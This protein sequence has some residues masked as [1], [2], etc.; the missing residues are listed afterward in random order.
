MESCTALNIQDSLQRVPLDVGHH[1][2]T[3]PLSRTERFLSNHYRP[4][5]EFTDSEGG[6]LSSSPSACIHFKNLFSAKILW[7]ASPHNRSQR[8]KYLHNRSSLPHVKSP[9]SRKTPSTACLGSN[10]RF[11]RCISSHSHSSLS[12]QISGILPQQK[13]IL[14]PSSSVRSERSPLHLYTTDEMAPISA[15][16][17]IYRCHSL[18]GRLDNLESECSSNPE[19]SARNHTST[20]VLRSFNKLEE[21][22]SNTVSR[23]NLAGSPMAHIQGKM[24]HTFNKNNEDQDFNFGNFVNT[25]GNSSTMGK[26][27]RV[28]KLHLPDTQTLTTTSSTLTQSSIISSSFSKRSTCSSP[29]STRRGFEEM[30]RREDLLPTC[31]LPAHKEYNPPLDGRL[32]IRVGRSHSLPTSLWRMEPSGSTTPYK[33]TGSKSSHKSYPGT[34]P[35]EC[36]N[37][38]LY[39]QSGSTVCYQQTEVQITEIATRD[40]VAISSNRT[41]AHPN[42]SIQDLVSDEQP[43][44]STQQKSLSILGVGDPPSNFS[45]H[46]ELEG[47]TPHRSNGNFT[48]CKITDLHIG[49]ERPKCNSHQCHSPRLES[50][51]R[52]IHFSPEVANPSSNR[53]TRPLQTPRSDNPPMVPSRALVQQNPAT[54]DIIQRTELTRS[55]E[56]WTSSLREM[57]RLQFLKQVLT[58]QHD[59][60]IAEELIQAHRS[61]T[62]KQAQSVWK[63]FKN[64]LP[65][66]ISKITKDTVLHFL[67]YLNEV[68]GL[69]PQT[70][71]NYKSCLAWPLKTAF[72]LNL[73]ESCFSLLT[74]TQFLKNPPRR[75]KIPTWSIDKALETFSSRAF[76]N[77]II[78]GEKLLLKALFLT[79]LATGNRAS[80]L[81]STIREGVVMNN[82]MVHLPVQRSFLFKNQSVSN[83]SPP[84]INFPVL[85]NNNTLCPW[86]C[87]KKY[88]ET[89][90]RESH[91]GFIFINPKSFKPLKAG[92]F[93]YWL[94]KSIRMADDAAIKPAGHDVRKFGHSIAFTRGEDPT[95]I[96]KNGFWH[97]PNVFVHKYLISC[98]SSSNKQFVAGRT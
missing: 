84:S 48:Q 53:K 21:I 30:A 13:V 88:I 98:N 8:T 20:T 94:V 4:R 18:S 29:I 10:S 22:K 32:P 77:Q 56:R 91:E 43:R 57:D 81:A 11:T 17:K 97:S 71:L 23:P 92:R 24:D 33:S 41:Q 7:R 14:F 67:I 37:T 78:T 79:A 31:I 72:N 38:S 76:D 3:T 60:K 49:K 64:W 44:R 27:N 63:C 89:T 47:N 42:K 86:L 25:S 65:E 50:V 75:K 52:N 58:N 51:D 96:I 1:S 16:S 36:V 2:T 95:T 35:N 80:E 34:K 68:K 62:S 93:S 28:A 19:G 59:S 73:N 46:N 61:S 90:D 15:S 39:R 66:D 12:A 74:K 85:G 54:D 26:F 83:P 82:N 40:K 87:L 70:I 55:N 5:S 6:S 45:S 9:R 69:S